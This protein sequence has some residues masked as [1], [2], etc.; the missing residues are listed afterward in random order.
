[1]NKTTLCTIII[2]LLVVIGSA[3]YVKSCAPKTDKSVCGTEADTVVVTRIDTV[4]VYIRQAVATRIDT[5]LVAGVPVEIAHLDTVYVSYGDS[6]KLSVTY[7]EKTNQFDI[8][9]YYTRLNET[10]TKTYLKN[11]VTPFAWIGGINPEW[12]TNRKW[13]FDAVGFDAGFRVY[14]KWDIELTGDTAGMIGLRLGVRF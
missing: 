3:V 13:A 11:A 2:A 1:M 10:L 8:D 7:D 14:E 12:D 6:T 5:V 9:A 4:R